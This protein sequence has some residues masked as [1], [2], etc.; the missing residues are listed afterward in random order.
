ESSSIFDLQLHKDI[1]PAV[2]YIRDV[3]MKTLSL[4]SALKDIVLTQY[5]ALV[6][7][8]QGSELLILKGAETLLPNFRYVKSE[9]ADCELY[10]GAATADKLEEFLKSRG[11]RLR[12]R[13]PFAWHPKRGQVSDLLFERC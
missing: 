11:F 13:V 9:A 6:L 10:K 12:R 2:H 1:W 5:D 3:R 7:D 4:R 8:T